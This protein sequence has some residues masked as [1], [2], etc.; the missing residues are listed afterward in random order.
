MTQR[1]FL[2]RPGLNRSIPIAPKPIRPRSAA[3]AAAPR[4]RSQASTHRTLPHP[5]QRC[6]HTRIFSHEPKQGGVEDDGGRPRAF[7]GQYPRPRTAA[8]LL[9]G[10]RVHR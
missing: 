4:R 8:A 1:I 7:I 2:S 6:I 5:L 9:A 10:A 3:A